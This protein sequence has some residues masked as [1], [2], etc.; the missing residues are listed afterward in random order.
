MSLLK[1]A[2]VFG[3]NVAVQDRG[4]AH[5]GSRHAAQSRGLH[6]GAR[7]WLQNVG[8]VPAMDPGAERDGAG[9]GQ[10]QWRAGL[11]SAGERRHWLAV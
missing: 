4:E 7:Q 10:G 6:G 2:L 3:L 9:R 8:R 1:A 11:P 5:Y